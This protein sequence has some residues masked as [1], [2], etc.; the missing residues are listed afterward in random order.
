MEAVAADFEPALEEIELGAF[1]G[2]VGTFNDDERAGIGSA[3]DRAAGLGKRSFGGL[4]ARRR[5]DGRVLVV[6]S[7]DRSV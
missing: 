1:A 4:R 5:F 6:H 2:A 3:G 7:L